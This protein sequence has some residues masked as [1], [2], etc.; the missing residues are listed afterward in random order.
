M[1]GGLAVTPATGMGEQQ[2]AIGEMVQALMLDQLFHQPLR[3]KD[4]D[5][6]ISGRFF[7]SPGELGNYL[8]VLLLD[9]YCRFQ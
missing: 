8:V 5:R 6:G 4:I 2:V 3:S 7:D 9:R 1:F